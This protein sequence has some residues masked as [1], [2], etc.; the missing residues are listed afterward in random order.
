[1]GR[2]PMINVQ[3]NG[4]PVT[5]V[6]DTGAQIS[7]ISPAVAAAAKLETVE[8]TLPGL[9]GAQ[10]ASIVSRRVVSA[11]VTYPG[12]EEHHLFAVTECPPD[13]ILLGIDF[14]GKAGFVIDM[15]GP[16]IWVKRRGPN[17]PPTAGGVMVQRPPS[18]E[19]PPAECPIPE[20]VRGTLGPLSD[21]P[22]D[23]QVEDPRVTGRP[24]SEPVGAPSPRKPRPRRKVG[25]RPSK[26]RGP[27]VAAVTSSSGEQGGVSSPGPS[28]SVPTGLPPSNDHAFV[29]GV[30]VPD[31][32]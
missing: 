26:L 15:D 13:L 28:S 14:G 30:S 10:G 12:G 9:R 20:I 31:P 19:P 4:Y 32:P 3:L 8:C 16:T 17:S 21:P 7:S 18:W 5:A 1:M 29:A 23:G 2:L 27:S 25:R 22:S 11:C 24:F 6:V